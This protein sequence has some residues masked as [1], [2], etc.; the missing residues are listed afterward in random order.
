M[1]AR[2]E[3]GMMVKTGMIVVFLVA[4]CGKEA[5]VVLND[6]RGRPKPGNVLYTW[7]R[8][9]KRQVSSYCCQ[10]PFPHPCASG[11]CLHAKHVRMDRH[12]R[13]LYASG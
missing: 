2:L 4:A 7:G 10:L 11:A 1:V 12:P 13:N 3:T 8:N 6:G 9:D 5:K